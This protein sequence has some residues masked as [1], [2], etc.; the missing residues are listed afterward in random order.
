M[1]RIKYYPEWNW[2]EIKTE[3]DNMVNNMKNLKCW[4]CYF[5]NI[6]PRLRQV[7]PGE[8]VEFKNFDFF[9]FNKDGD[10]CIQQVLWILNEKIVCEL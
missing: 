2:N 5:T 9:V 1:S 4:N 8:N 10:T 3:K 7:S 6:G